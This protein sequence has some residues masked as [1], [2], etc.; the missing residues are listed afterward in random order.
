MTVLAV[1]LLLTVPLTAQTS[2]P[3][4]M[5]LTRQGFAAE[6]AGD[7]ATAAKLYRQGAELGNLHAQHL[8]G[9][10][11][12]DGRHVPKDRKEAYRLYSLAAAQ[13]H[14]DSNHHVG[15]M[16]FTGNPVPENREQAIAYLRRSA[17]LGYLP[18][19]R[20]L[21]E[22]GLLSDG[23]GINAGLVNYLIEYAEAKPSAELFDAVASAYR[24]NSG[25][26]GFDFGRAALYS[27]R[28]EALSAEEGRR[29]IIAELDELASWQAVA[30]M[31]GRT[32]ETRRLAGYFESKTPPQKYYPEARR[33]YLLAAELGDA[34]SMISAAELLRD[35]RAGTPNE[36]LATQWLEKGIIAAERDGL[37]QVVT[38]G[39][40]QLVRTGQ[41]V[42]GASLV[43]KAAQN[44]DRRAVRLH[45]AIR[46]DPSVNV[47]PCTISDAMRKAYR[48]EEAAEQKLVGD[49]LR[50]LSR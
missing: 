9:H 1:T 22:I 43:C 32:E 38:S 28:A 12:E 3:P 50:D 34:F 40:S 7:L 6:R 33:L 4:G 11:Y 2:D 15:M 8:L 20:M 17:E 46:V 45:V 29:K 16:L 21:G 27:R 47:P 19:K 30:G 35:A 48:V 13:G 26:L 14:P 36:A 39:A 24:F 42:R 5:D 37:W 10:L 44:G 31:S 23:K 25:G 41:V 49:M 18:G